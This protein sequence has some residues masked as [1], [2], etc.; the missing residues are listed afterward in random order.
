MGF[1]HTSLKSF[2]STSPSYLRVNTN[3][4]NTITQRYLDKRALVFP[5][6]YTAR[7]GIFN[8][9]LILKLSKKKKKVLAGYMLSKSAVIYAYGARL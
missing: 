3:Y 2:Y 4:S 6:F 1:S 8:V 7:V 5:L 9:V